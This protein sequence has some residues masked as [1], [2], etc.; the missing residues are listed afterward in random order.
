MAAGKINLQKASGGIT[1]IT[2]VDGTG[3]TQLV[4]PES[5]TVATT[6]YVDGK[7]VRGTTVTASGTSIDFTGI[8]SWVKRITVMFSG[9]STNGSSFI[10][11][12]L[13]V[14]GGFES[15]GYIGAY[16]NM[17]NA[18]ATNSG[19][20]TNGFD[21]P[22]YSGSNYYSG[23]LVIENINGNTFV[24]N[25]LYGNYGV[26]YGGNIVCGLK[27]LSGVLDRIRITTANGT[28]IFDAGQINIMYEG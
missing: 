1:A 19:P 3:N 7:F 25:G 18:N 16:A 23:N 5:G 11:L 2:G 13:G 12:Q 28:D 21:C 10:R 17:T 26:T 14:S 9:V 6:E 27:T 20:F 24:V 22:N 4:L 15:S 8:P